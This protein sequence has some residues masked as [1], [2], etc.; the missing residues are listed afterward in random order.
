MNK[1]E[2]MIFRHTLLAPEFNVAINY[3]QRDIQPVSIDTVDKQ[4]RQS[5]IGLKDF[6]CFVS[7][8]VDSSTLA[9]IS[10]A[11]VIY[12]ASFPSLKQDES[13]WAQKVADSIG[14]ELRIVPINKNEYLATLEYLIRNKKD[15]LHPN[16]PCLYIV[17][18]KAVRDGFETILSGEGADDIFGGY[19]D[20]LQNEHK[21]LASEKAFLKRYAYLRPREFGL[22]EYIN[23]PQYKKWGMERFIL[24]VHTPGLIHRAQNA[25]WSAGIKPLFPYLLSGLP[26]IM[27]QAPLE[28]KKGKALL[29]KLAEKYLPYEIVYRQK[30]GFPVPLDLWLGE[31]GIANFILLNIKIWENLS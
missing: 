18:K 12:T 30:V 7:G 29:K 14:A 26:Q 13:E 27:W 8:G 5:I 19:T 11:K 23:F 16:E 9:A 20:L 3:D 15:G 22:K 1:M 6:T 10:G 17:A 28:A 4:L 25:C 21:Y 31:P 2:Y 24:E